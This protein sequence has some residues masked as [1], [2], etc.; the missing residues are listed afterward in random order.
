MHSSGKGGGGC[1]GETG[2]D[3][4]LLQEA[5]LPA[6]GLFLEAVD[7][8]SQLLDLLLGG[9]EGVDLVLDGHHVPLH[10]DHLALAALHALRQVLQLR[11][12]RTHTRTPVRR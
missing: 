12:A 1:T 4:Y 3:W 8:V 6:S 7:G 9:L 10:L 5:D 11:P 2:S